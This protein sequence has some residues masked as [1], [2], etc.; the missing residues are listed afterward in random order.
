MG[1]Q[2]LLTPIPP[3][4]MEMYFLFLLGLKPPPNNGTATI[5]P[6]GMT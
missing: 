4:I 6:D 1:M 5:N 3:S 2:L